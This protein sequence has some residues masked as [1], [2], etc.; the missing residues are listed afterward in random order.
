M[1]TDASMDDATTAPP[2]TQ[3]LPAPP[4]PRVT[5]WL[6]QLLTLTLSNP[7]LS[8]KLNGKTGVSLITRDIRLLTHED[9]SAPCIKKILGALEG[10]KELAFRPCEGPALMPYGT[11]AMTEELF[12]EAN[13]T[14]TA[15]A[16]TC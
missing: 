3:L 12:V 11:A 8:L 16:T 10:L 2:P 13:A 6:S 5:E 1:T 15:T 7:L 14:D 9:S 4:P